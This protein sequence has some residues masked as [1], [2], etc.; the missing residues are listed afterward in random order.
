MDV[1]K[2]PFLVF[3]HMHMGHSSAKDEAVCEV[4]HQ[5]GLLLVKDSAHK[6]GTVLGSLTGPKDVHY[7]TPM[8]V[9]SHSDEIRVFFTIAMLS[10]KR[11]LYQRRPSSLATPVPVKLSKEGPVQVLG[12]VTAPV[13][14][15]LLS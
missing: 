14:L 6:A 2:T 9:A 11:A 3:Y 4:V 13:L 15:G 8:W 12:W 7:L 1:R 10:R 5:L